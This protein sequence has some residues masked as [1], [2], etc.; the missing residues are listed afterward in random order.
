VGDRDGRLRELGGMFNNYSVLRAWTRSSRRHHVPGCPPRPEA[1]VEGIVRLQEK[2]KA[3]VPPAYEIRGGRVVSYEG[4]PGLVET[5]GARRDDARRRPGAARRGLPHL[6]DEQGFNFLSDITPTDYL[7]WAERASPATS[8]RRRPRHQRAGRRARAAADA[9]AEAL[10]D[11]LPPARARPS[12][13]RVRVQVWLDDGEPCRASS[14]LADRR[15][16]RARGLGHDGHPIEG[17][18]NL[19]R[20]L[21]EDDWEGHPLRKDYPIGGEPVRFSEEE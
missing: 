20:I 21:M 1:L 12:A 8:A 5:R 10:L 4:V 13:D 19:A 7:G 18:P 9:E 15:L 17:H 14:G 11:E 2:I 16:A 3:G 6:R